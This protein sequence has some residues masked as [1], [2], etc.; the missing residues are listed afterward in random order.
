MPIDIELPALCSA[1][2]GIEFIYCEPRRLRDNRRRTPAPHHDESIRDV[3]QR[4][5]P[6]R[7]DHGEHDT[8]VRSGRNGQPTRY[9][10]HAA[11]GKAFQIRL[12]RAHSMQE[13]FVQQKAARRRDPETSAGAIDEEVELL[14]RAGYI[15][16]DVTNHPL[17]FGFFF[18]WL[19]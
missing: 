8:D 1:T 10:Q 9:R 15:T 3:F 18:Q 12:I 2:E 4:D 5:T 7:F 19:E 6:Q 13:I 17:H 14:L 16:S 11:D